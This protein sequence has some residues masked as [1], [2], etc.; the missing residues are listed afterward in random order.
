MKLNQIQVGG[1]YVAKVSRQLV[2]LRVVEVKEIPP[3]A[4]SSPGAAWRTHIHAV[5]EATGR[6]I[7]I[8]SPQRLRGPAKE[9]QP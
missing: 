8:R 2:V 4:W 5:N 9:G 3:P 6:K 1:R 7:I